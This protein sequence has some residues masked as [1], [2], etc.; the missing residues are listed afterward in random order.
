MCVLPKPS[1]WRL[2]NTRFYFMR[3][4][5]LKFKLTR[6]TTNYKQTSALQHHL[7]SPDLDMNSSLLWATTS[8]ITLGSSGE[9]L[10]T[11]AHKKEP[12]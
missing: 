5:S 4:L 7:S 12:I 8:F 6:L 10:C 11:P 1:K 2:Q 9:M 3:D